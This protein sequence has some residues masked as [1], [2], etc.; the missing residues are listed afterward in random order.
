MVW[1][2]NK[3]TLLCYFSTANQFIAVI[4]IVQSM[5]LKA[6]NIFNKSVFVQSQLLVK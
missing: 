4:K 6:H 5:T 1:K 2:L 3:R